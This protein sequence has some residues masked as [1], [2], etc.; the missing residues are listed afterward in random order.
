VFLIFPTLFLTSVSL[1]IEAAKSSCFV[2]IARHYL[3]N[4]FKNIPV[5]LELS[6]DIRESLPAHSLPAVI[7]HTRK[8]FHD[9]KNQKET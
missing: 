2:A 6:N 5:A 1:A 9:L 4:S 7:K 8:F 3:P